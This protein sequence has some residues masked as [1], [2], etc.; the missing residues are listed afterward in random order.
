MSKNYHSK[1]KDKYHDTMIVKKNEIVNIS[2]TKIYHQ[3]LYQRFSYKIKEFCLDLLNTHVYLLSRY[4]QQNFISL[5]DATT[6]DPGS[7]IN[8]I[9]GSKLKSICEER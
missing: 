5:Y 6:D 1:Q 8:L 4:L 3:L 2:Q 7:L 9:Y